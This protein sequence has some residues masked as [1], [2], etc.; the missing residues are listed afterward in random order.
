M[1]AIAGQEDISVVP[2]FSNTSA[3]V[4]GVGNWTITSPVSGQLCINN[5]D[6][7]QVSLLH[8]AFIQINS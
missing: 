5:V 6:G 8:L 2:I 3:A 7:H 1:E 4:I